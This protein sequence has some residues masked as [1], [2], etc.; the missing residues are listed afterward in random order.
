MLLS[1]GGLLAHTPPLF[2]Q[3]HDFVIHDIQI[4][5]P[6]HPPRSFRP[7]TPAWA[8]GPTLLYLVPNCSEMLHAGRRFRARMTCRARGAYPLA[9]PPRRRRSREALCPPGS[10]VPPSCARATPRPCRP[11][12]RRARG[13]RRSGERSTPSAVAAAVPMTV[14]LPLPGVP[15]PGVPPPLLLLPS[16]LAACRS[17]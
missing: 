14:P 11:R 13:F 9:G 5:P 1:S 7:P 12:H 4:K 16:L 10:S 2:Q 6:T 3:K 17:R 15:L 8:A